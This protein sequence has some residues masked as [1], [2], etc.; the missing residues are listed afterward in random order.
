MAK[1]SRVNNAIR[2]V[3]TALIF[4]TVGTLLGFYAR[5]ILI[6]ALGAEIVGLNTTATNLIGFLNISELGISTIIAYTLYAPLARGDRESIG[7]I[8]T[9]QGWIYRRV[10]LF[11]AAGSVVMMALFPLIFAKMEIPLWYAYAS[12]GVILLG[13]L[14]GY[15][16]NYQ[17]VM[18][19][20][21][22]RQ[23]RV[24]YRYHGIRLLKMVVQI[25][26][27]AHFGMGYK[28][29]LITEAVAALL[30]T[31]ALRQAVVSGYGW[32]HRSTKGIKELLDRHPDVVIKSKQ[33]IFHRVGGYTLYQLSPLIV[34]G[35][36][37]LTA[38]TIYTNYL[39]I[40]NG[41]IM[42]VGALSNGLVAGIGN[43]AAEGDKAKDLHLYR[44]IF[45]FRFWV[46]AICCY[47]MY[48][49]STSFVV[50][51]VGEEYL[52]DNLTLGLMTLYTF[53][54]ITRVNDLFTAAYGL[55]SDIAAPIIEAVIN[56][57]LSMLLGYYF[58]I[59]GIVAGV[60]ISLL[61]IV[62]GWKSYFLFSRGFRV[63]VIQY[64]YVLAQTMVVVAVAW[65]VSDQLL[66]YIF[67][68]N[69]DSL[70]GW[71]VEGAKGVMLFGV[72]S[73]LLFALFSR[74]YREFVRQVIRK[75]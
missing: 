51:W 7:E 43:L 75:K 63:S 69:S 33:M 3:R 17:Q 36:L 24:D 32:L 52:L 73:T 42:I 34:Y 41:I 57:A 66:P 8:I 47:A 38:V 40:A 53:I 59:A 25:I 13:S 28:F 14:L 72:I 71:L 4:T 61:V 19:I 27:L 11:V 54:M 15:L 46:A 2:N 30:T 21:D 26:G 20:A 64:I 62:V 49:L 1:S 37:S 58:G 45:A 10:A 68:P 39:L 18:L 60:I 35:Y 12:F 48:H 16:F 50:L 67:T 31:V 6:E 23:D 29:W 22:Q 65:L 9:I 55:C 5:R 44:T 74:H 56:I 70:V